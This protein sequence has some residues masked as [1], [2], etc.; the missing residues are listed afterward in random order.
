MSA[1]ESLQKLMDMSMEEI[2]QIQNS[3]Q[4]QLNHPLKLIRETHHL[5]A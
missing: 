4:L 1:Q 3:Q 2:P 5:P